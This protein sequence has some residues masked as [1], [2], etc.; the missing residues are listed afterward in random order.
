MKAET[1]KLRDISEGI[2]QKVDEGILPTNSVYL[3]VNLVFDKILGRAVLREGTTQLG[4]QIVDGKECLG[5][6]EHITTA[7]VKVPIA[8]FNDATNT[9]ADVYKY[10]SS[11]WSKAKEDVTQGVKMRFETFLN[12]TIGVNGTDKISTADGSSWVTTG[13]NLDI[14]N[15]PAATLVKEWKDKIYCAGVSTNPDRLYF[16]SVP[17]AGVISW[18]VGNGYI[19]IEP[20]DG[21]GPI[22][23]LA[24]VPGYLL[25]IKERSV[26]RWDGSQTYPDDLIS[27][28]TYSQ[29]CVVETRQSCFYFN[30]RGIYETTGGY[31]RKISRK[32]QGIIDAIPSSY[33]IKV[34][35]WGD[36]ER[37]MYSIGDITLGDLALTNCV[38]MYN[39]ESQIWTLLSFPNELKMWH[40]YVDANGDEIILA[41]DDDGNVWQ[42]FEG[43]DDG[44]TMITWLLQYQT[45]E[46]GSRGKIKDI[47][48][49]ISYGENIQSGL[50]S[51]KVNNRGSFIPCGGIHN[52][53]E[54]IT[55]DINGQYFDFRI[56]GQGRSTQI[57]G[58]DFPDI[59][60]TF[61]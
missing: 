60:V 34:S 47:S 37:V 15:M 55:K 32:I 9:N 33:Y 41:G 57:I 8:V 28:G 17:S 3:A 49:I 24:K 38:V 7:G 52:S 16:S 23:A 61:N 18:T 27:I 2:I 42:I 56:Q 21:A 11:A 22:R 36:G 45:Q 58:L 29:E 19:D 44:G 40:H 50:L 10:T 25:I 20:E 53:V 14:G 59:N 26:K 43:T 4:S 39:I 30:K 1:Q 51:C 48:K 46:F 6:H 13:G 35:G 12:T 31:P 54:E 5:L